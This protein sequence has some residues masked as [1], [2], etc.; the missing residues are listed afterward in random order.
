MN[1][2]LTQRLNG[3][4][5]KITSKEFLSGKGL[6]KEIPFYIFDYP[7][8]DELQVRE[9][10][11]FLLAHIPRHRPGLR[12]KHI[13][14]FD[15]IIDYLKERNLLDRSIKMQREKGDEA[16]AGALSGPLKAERLVQIFAQ[17]AQPQ[18]HDL[19]LVSG[20]GSV[21]PLVRSHTLLNNLQTV[22]GE[23]PLVMFYP[24]RYD[25]QTLRLFGKVN[26][27]P[28]YRAFKLIP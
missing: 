6:S 2:L 10:I 12:V 25:G 3:I 26:S 19:I 17:T 13:N 16:L 9:H 20:V 8:E 1:E 21:W 7:P 14:L 28:Y 5:P 15:L 4:L 18:D 11:L 24:G 22:M 23:T 27:A